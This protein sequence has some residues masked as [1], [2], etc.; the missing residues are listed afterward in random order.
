V[1]V[2]R[3]CVCVVCC[4]GRSQFSIQ[5]KRKNKKP[6][7]SLIPYTVSNSWHFEEKTLDFTF[8][9]ETSLH[10]WQMWNALNCHN[11]IGFWRACFVD[12]HDDGWQSRLRAP[13]ST[14]E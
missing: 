9:N 11:S 13:S 6:V 14:G 5:P 7:R 2:G 10:L 12:C 1:A 3:V 8:W 4:R